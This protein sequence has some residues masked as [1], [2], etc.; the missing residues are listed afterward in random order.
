MT[1]PEPSDFWH[2][3]AY[4]CGGG[5]AF[6]FV[7]DLLGW[8]AGR[9][10]RASMTDAQRQIDSIDIAALRQQTEDR[11]EARAFDAMV[12]LMK[13][14]NERHQQCEAE[15]E[16]DRAENERYRL[17]NDHR[18]EVMRSY[19]QAMREAMIE[20]DLKPPPVPPELETW[21]APQRPT[22]G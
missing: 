4:L 2:L 6:K 9:R 13:D 12:L 20:A 18:F 8:W 10:D 22:A 21:R 14:S 5:A 16:R 7:I 19:M 17:G 15:R 11:K 1:T 3:F